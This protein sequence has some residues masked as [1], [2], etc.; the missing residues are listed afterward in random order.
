[1]NK[2][3]LP[4][5]ATQADRGFFFSLCTAVP[6]EEQVLPW[7]PDLLGFGLQGPSPASGF[8]LNRCTCLIRDFSTLKMFN[9]FPTCLRS[10]IRCCSDSVCVE[11]GRPIITTLRSFRSLSLL[12]AAIA[13]TILTAS[14]LPLPFAAMLLHSVLF[15]SRVLGTM[16]WILDFKLIYCY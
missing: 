9:M 10:S 4:A 3:M 16:F 12:T 13:L 7:F 5:V 2:P 14:D 8:V 15:R 6:V 1:M 11:T